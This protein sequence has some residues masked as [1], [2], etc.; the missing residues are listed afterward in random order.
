MS[1]WSIMNWVAWGLA[2]FFVVL[3]VRD[4]IRTEREIRSKE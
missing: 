1:I 3:M 4:F 2:V